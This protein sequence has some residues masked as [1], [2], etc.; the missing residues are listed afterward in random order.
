MDR[1]IAIYT[2][3]KNEELNSSS[4]V[5]NVKDADY[6]I[7]GDT[8]SQDQTICILEKHGVKVIPI[9]TDPWRFDHARNQLLSQIPDDVDICISLDFDERLNDGWRE[10][11]ESAWSDKTTKLTHRYLEKLEGNYHLTNPIITSRI[12]SRKGYKW[13]Y[14]V[15]ETLQY[16]LQK[17]EQVVFCSKL[18]IVHTPDRSKSRSNYLK[19][20]ELSVKENPENL[21]FFHNLGRLYFQHHRYDEC[22]NAMEHILKQTHVSADLSVASKRYIYR[23]Y[24]E[25]QQYGFSKK[26]LLEMIEEHSHCS[27]IYAELCTL[28]YKNQDFETIL[29]VADK[30]D[31]I[32]FH[33][34]SIYNEFAN[35]P[36]LLYD[37][38]S[39]AYF[40]QKHYPQAM[41]FAQKAFGLD[42]LNVRLKNNVEKIKKFV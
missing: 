19:L 16:M 30:I 26:K 4:W 17:E 29:Q 23:A 8:G 24:A 41:E 35:V 42:P 15:H 21:M 27:S 40:K 33:Y 32:E 39:F 22:I 37:I 5:E 13:V 9:N 12:H 2:I 18:E 34:K 38:I 10:A 28:A 6:I 3:C 11:V 36:S 25:K 1:R 7:V 31:A 20:M 14:P